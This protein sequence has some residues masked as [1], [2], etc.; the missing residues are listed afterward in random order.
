MGNDTQSRHIEGQFR[1]IVQVFTASL[2][3]SAPLLGY[4]L[5][6]LS[7][8]DS[9][10]N[11]VS[12]FLPFLVLTPL[13][14]LIPSAYLIAFL[15]KEIFKW[16]SYIRVYLEDGK[17]LKYETELAKYRDKFPESES[18]NAIAFTYLAF[19]VICAVAFGYGLHASSMSSLWLF[20]LVV[21]LCF[22]L[23]WYPSYRSIPSQCSREYDSR[24]ASVKRDSPEV[25]SALNADCQEVNTRLDQIQKSITG[26]G[27]D[28]KMLAS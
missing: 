11:T 22:V 18:F 16:G 25:K 2:V 13:A 15:R 21:P 19:A 17:E 20:V 10:A 4:G 14:I 23:H 5:R 1:L 12:H 27:Q 6:V 8:T 28:L 24:W 3:V 7:E 9:A 26:I